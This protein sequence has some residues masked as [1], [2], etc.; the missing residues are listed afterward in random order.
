M[1]CYPFEFNCPDARACPC[2]PDVPSEMVQAA[3]PE[4]LD[5]DPDFATR[6]IAESE[7]GSF[8]A[9]QFLS[10]EEL[11]GIDSAPKLPGHV[12]ALI[13]VCCLA[14]GLLIALL[15]AHSAWGDK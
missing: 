13:W 3:R 9:T 1:K 12:R 5:T 6:L 7:K 11:A 2:T 15:A 8:E 10:D 14:P 4:W